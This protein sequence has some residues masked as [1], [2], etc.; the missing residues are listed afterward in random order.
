[1]IPLKKFTVL[2]MSFPPAPP[3]LVFWCFDIRRTAPPKVSQI[4]EITQGVGDGSGAYL[5]NAKQSTQS[6]TVN[7]FLC[8]ALSLWAINLLPSSSW[9]RDQITRNRAYTSRFTKT[10]PTS[11]SW[12]WL[13]C[14]SPSCHENHQKDCCSHFPLTCLPHGW[15]WCS[16]VGRCG[17]PCLQSGGNA[18]RFQGIFS[19]AVWETQRLPKNVLQT[20]SKMCRLMK[21][22]TSRFLPKSFMRELWSVLAEFGL[23][24]WYMIGYWATRHSISFI[25]FKVCGAPRIQTQGVQRSC[26]LKVLLTLFWMTPLVM[27]TPFLTFPHTSVSRDLWM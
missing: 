26:F 22:K 4:L 21:V 5:S 12:I 3:L 27:L 8:G 13:T 17:I 11:Q 14:F 15:R 2:V 20:A 24:V 6:H 9:T 25:Q 16:H 7:Y 18:N 10:I 23:T 19:I 1:M